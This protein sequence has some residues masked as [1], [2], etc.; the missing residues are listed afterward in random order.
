MR[1]AEWMLILLVQGFLVPGI[2]AWRL[3]VLVWGSSLRG[4]SLGL[5][6]GGSYL[7]GCS[8]R[9]G[10]EVC[11]FWVLS[12]CIEDFL[13]CFLNVSLLGGTLPKIFV[14]KAMASRPGLSFAPSGL[15]VLLQTGTEQPQQHRVGIPC[16]GSWTLTDMC[17]CI[18]HSSRRW[19]VGVGEDHR[20]CSL[21]H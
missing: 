11:C 7:G 21:P 18:G 3:L 16:C 2:L 15:R 4:C 14:E 17:M 1:L 10:S 8:C 9:A 19:W 5:G 13:L 12:R 20:A 6:G